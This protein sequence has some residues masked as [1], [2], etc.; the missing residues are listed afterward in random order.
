MSDLMNLV[1]YLDFVIVANVVHVSA[2]T[3]RA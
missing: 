3:N 1:D 2:L